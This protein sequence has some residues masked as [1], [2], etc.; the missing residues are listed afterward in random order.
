MLIEE[1]LVQTGVKLMQHEATTR[2]LIKRI[3][4]KLEWLEGKELELYV[5]EH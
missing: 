4:S 5:M 2:S 3:N 1:R